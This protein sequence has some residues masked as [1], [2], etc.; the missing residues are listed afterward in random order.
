MDA[1]GSQQLWLVL[2]LVLHTLG[3]EDAAELIERAQAAWARDHSLVG[4]MVSISARLDLIDRLREE[5][6]VSGQEVYAERR[7]RDIDQL[8]TFL[9]ATCL[10]IAQGGPD[11]SGDA[12]FQSFAAGLPPWVQ[13]WLG[14]T[15][16]LL[17]AESNPEHS[18]PEWLAKEP[19]AKCRLVAAHLA[20]IAR[21]Y[22]Q[23]VDYAPWDE[24]D[25][26]HATEAIRNARYEF[27]WFHEAG[28][29]TLEGE[30]AVGI[31]AGMP[32]SEILRFLLVVRLRGWLDLEDDSSL[33]D[34]Y[35]SRRRL[36]V[37]GL[38]ALKEMEDNIA[39]IHAWSARD[40]Y[41][42]PTKADYAPIAGL[43]DQGVR[44]L[45]EDTESLSRLGGVSLEALDLYLD[46]LERV[47]ARIAALN[48]RTED[49]AFDLR[50]KAFE[51]SALFESLLGDAETR[52]LV[53]QVQLLHIQLSRSVSVGL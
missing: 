10:A 27:L 44:T 11:P 48:Q 14:A 28:S 4:R 2:P 21:T 53:T 7:W 19:A 38:R 41:E 8:T 20:A 33:I 26:L 40:L 24:H 5:R 18:M 46:D 30:T 16:V 22:P 25:R 34:R 45:A 52:D 51:E 49:P 15:Y 35:W 31:K 37:W 23:V 43:P 50:G 12:T 47:N 3:D 1:D 32:E 13:E 6:T 9:A 39:R 17:P 36:R 29:S 42:R